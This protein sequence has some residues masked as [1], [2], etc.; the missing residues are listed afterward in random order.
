[1]LREKLLGNRH[2]ATEL[3]ARVLAAQL[4]D[5]LVVELVCLFGPLLQR[6]RLSGG[7]VFEGGLYRGGRDVARVHP[8]REGAE[9]GVV[10]LGRRRALGPREPVILWPYR[11]CPCAFLNA[12]TSSSV[13]SSGRTGAWPPRRM[14]SC[15]AKSASATAS[16]VAYRS[17]RLRRAASPRDRPSR[18]LS[19]HAGAAPPASISSMSSAVVPVAAGG[20]AAAPLPAPLLRPL[21]TPRRGG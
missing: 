13:A 2:V 19:P 7:V 16:G 4:G 14:R 18:Q 3:A 5:V 1:M 17:R 6:C 20:A 10:G 15:A 8:L 21:P 9:R 11:G 12:L